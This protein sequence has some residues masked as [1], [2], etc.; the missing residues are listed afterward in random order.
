VVLDHDFAAG[1]WSRLFR[2]E[3]P[4]R[5]N[6]EPQDWPAIAVDPLKEALGRRFQFL[7]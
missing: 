4:V 6:V 2:D 7:L 1:C 3:S 5:H